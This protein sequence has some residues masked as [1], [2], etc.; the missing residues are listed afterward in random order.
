MMPLLAKIQT[1]STGKVWCNNWNIAAGAKNMEQLSSS[2][3]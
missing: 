1:E 3:S 2:T